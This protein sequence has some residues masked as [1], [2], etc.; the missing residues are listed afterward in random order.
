MNCLFLSHSLYQRSRK[1]RHVMDY[2]GSSND[3]F[4]LQSETRESYYGL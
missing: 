1:N 2:L 3:I 4:Y